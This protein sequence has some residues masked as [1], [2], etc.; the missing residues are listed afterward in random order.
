MKKETFKIMLCIT[1]CSVLVIGNVLSLK[2]G[3]DKDKPVLS[4]DTLNV[5]IYDEQSKEGQAKMEAFDKYWTYSKYKF[6]SPEEFKRIN[7]D[8]NK[9]FMTTMVY[10]FFDNKGNLSDH[11]KLFVIFRGGNDYATSNDNNKFINKK[12]YI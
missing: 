12:Y 10:D 3:K 11:I 7:N 2:A 8:K 4:K 6:I 1:L 9:F 5:I